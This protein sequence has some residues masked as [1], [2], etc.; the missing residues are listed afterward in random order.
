[1]KKSL[2]ALIL[3]LC[4]SVGLLV[5]ACMGISHDIKTVDIT[6]TVLMGDS[7]EVQDIK[8]TE[9]MRLF[10]D[11][12]QWKLSYHPGQT[13][14]AEATLINDAVEFDFYQEWTG[15]YLMIPSNMG[16][17]STERDDFRQ[18]WEYQEIWNQ[19]EITEALSN[20]EKTGEMTVSCKLSDYYD[21]Y[22]IQWDLRFPYDY[23]LSWDC[24]V[25]RQE[26][27]RCM[28][29]EVKNGT[30]NS[31]DERLAQYHKVDQGLRNFFRFPVREEDV[32]TLTI[33]KQG[34]FYDGNYSLNREAMIRTAS[35]LT[36]R[37]IYFSIEPS[38]DIDFSQVPGG[39]GVYF[40]PYDTIPVVMECEDENGEVV[41]KDTFCVESVLADQIRTIYSLPEGERMMTVEASKDRKKVLL[42]TSDQNERR[43]LTVFDAETAAEVERLELTGNGK[44]VDCDQVFVG[45]D[46]LVIHWSNQT[47]TVLTQENE[48]WE[49]AFTVA[50]PGEAQ[51]GEVPAWLAEEFQRGNWSY[52][53]FSSSNVSYDW[54]GSRLAIFSS[55]SYHLEDSCL[56]VLD[57][58]GAR[59]VA[60]YHTS[61]GDPPALNGETYHVYSTEVSVVRRYQDSVNVR[62]NPA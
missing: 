23:E 51:L 47:L 39:L 1:M 22:P 31:S 55:A 42:F 32:L 18:E 7:K 11:S 25:L 8:L 5:S 44:P 27:Y 2:F 33:T 19:P 28:M 15:L 48:R 59:F 54:D 57:A 10:D 30:R 26:E 46:Y 17:T 40:L 36:D 4:L 58:T 41:T 29:E 45:Q 56:I 6:E 12:L 3:C 60:C 61:L 16:Y 53:L 21:E 13:S 35:A 24:V 50:L 37:G 43:F 20:L 49:E 38:A 52:L 14:P 34:E 62:W 9:E